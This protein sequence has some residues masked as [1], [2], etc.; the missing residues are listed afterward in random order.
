MYGNMYV[1]SNN[2]V[3]EILA[4]L[5]SERETVLMLL[6]TENDVDVFMS[7]FYQK[8]GLVIDDLLD[9]REYKIE[10]NNS[11]IIDFTSNCRTK[12]IRETFEQTFYQFF[13]INDM[14]IINESIN[15]GKIT[16]ELL[17]EKFKANPN[18]NI[19]KYVL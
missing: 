1:K 16:L 13:S 3:E 11:N 19:M 5:K 15:N 18:R 4:S 2:V 8:N 7:D 17:F 14:E 9:F 6:A 12:G 10:N